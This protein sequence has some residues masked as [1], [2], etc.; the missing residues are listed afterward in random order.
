MAGLL[1]LETSFA[2]KGLHLGYRRVV[3][4]GDCPLGAAGAS[5]RGHEFHYARVLDE[6]PG[7]PLFKVF[8]AAG[9]DLGSAGLAMGGVMG[10]FIHLIDREDDG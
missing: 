10:S 9:Q 4:E 5:F 2:D 8:D 7:R 6:G 3:L 1:P